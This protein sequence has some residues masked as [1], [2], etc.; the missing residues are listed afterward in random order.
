MNAPLRIPREAP[1][2]SY[3]PTEADLLCLHCPLADC[4]ESSP[5]CLLFGRLVPASVRPLQWQARMRMYKQRQRARI[6]GET[7]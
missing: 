2:E 1:Q 3:L 4:D 6:R 5:H 7:G